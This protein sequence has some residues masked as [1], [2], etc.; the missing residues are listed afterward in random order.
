MPLH[1]YE[2]NECGSIDERLE[3]G[4]EMDK[5][6]YCSKC[7]RLMSRIVSLC[8]FKLV[9][10]NKTDTCSWG[11]EGYASSQ[12]WREYKKARERGEDVKPA[13]ED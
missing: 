12:Y 1:D 7:N 5:E 11:N 9:Y 3:F 2:C 8:K 6:H 10:N 4:K 13:G